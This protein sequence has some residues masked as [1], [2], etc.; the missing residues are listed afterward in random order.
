[1]PSGRCHC[2]EIVYSFQGGVRHS[3]LCDCVDSRR[4]AGSAWVACFG[5][6]ADDFAFEQGEPQR[7]RSSADAERLFCG[8][9]GTGLVYI[10][11]NM[12]PGMVDI[13]TATLDYPDGF[14]P[15]EHVQMAD[16]LA[17]EATLHDLPKFD[18]FPG[19]T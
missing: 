1:M 10:N 19:Q 15:H 3:S 12:L 14:P 8:K 5:I 4:C 13:Q 11:E 17:W 18:R 6:A 16:A 2:G 9:C 7:Y